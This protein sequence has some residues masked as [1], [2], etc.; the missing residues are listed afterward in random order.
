[1]SQK[2]KYRVNLT[3]FT[4][5]GKY[6]SDGHYFTETEQPLFKIFDEVK[7]LCELKVLPG[8]REGHSD[9]YVLV[10]VPKHPNC[11]PCLITHHVGR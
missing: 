8:L 4:K 6:Y 7:R 10:N 2:K 5:T 3:Y 9:F 11:H 1:M